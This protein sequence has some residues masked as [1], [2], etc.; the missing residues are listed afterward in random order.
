MLLNKQDEVLETRVQ[1][2]LQP[3]MDN[4]GVV[5]AV[6]MGVDAVE[7]L[8]QLTHRGLEGLGEDDADARGKDGFVVDVGLHPGH[9]VFDVLG[10]GHLGGF[11]VAGRGVLPE[12]LE[13]VRW[14]GG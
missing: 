3:Q 4:D 10:R 8:E 5:V 1:V 6:D 7:A 2:R 14:E 13:P 12:V 11:G 9:Q